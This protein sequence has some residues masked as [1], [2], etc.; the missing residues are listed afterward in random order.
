MS[1]SQLR[2]VRL[3]LFSRQCRSYLSS[4]SACPM[5]SISPLRRKR[6]FPTM[7]PCR[8]K[9]KGTIISRFPTGARGIGANRETSTTWDWRYTSV[10]LVTRIRPVKSLFSRI[11]KF[12]FYCFWFW[13]ISSKSQLT[14]RS[15]REEKPEF[16]SPR[17]DKRPY[18][19]G[20]ILVIQ[21]KKINS[22]FHIF[23]KYMLS[24]VSM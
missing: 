21:L 19:R 12:S 8:Y 15:V 16:R 20:G 24:K 3:L 11:S 5:K 18:L 23:S 22:F 4:E 6:N 7:L 17:N 14:E 9:G 10:T 13:Q 2:P 1:R